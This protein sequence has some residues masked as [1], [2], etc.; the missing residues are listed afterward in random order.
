MTTEITNEPTATESIARMLIPYYTEGSKKAKYLSY[1]IA[2]FSVLES[3][4]LADI[5]LKTVMRWRDSDLVFVALENKAHT[6]LREELANQLIDIEFSRNFRLVLAKD[7]QV[8]FKDATGEQLTTS[9]QDYVK[10]IRKFYTP[11]Q[12]MMIKQLVSTNGQQQEAFDFTK[13]VLEIRL[14]RENIKSGGQIGTSGEGR[15]TD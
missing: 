3:V 1:I 9:E 13:T 12:Y 10:L 6:E 2:G 14:S 7:F 8:L 5:H 15:I 4:K 11:Q